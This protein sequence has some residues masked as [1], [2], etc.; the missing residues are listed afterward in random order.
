[1]FGFS[2]L[3]FSTSLTPTYNGS[4]ENFILYI[5]QDE[6][7]PLFIDQELD[8][9]FYITQDSNFNLFINQEEELLL[10]LQKLESA[11]L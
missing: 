2:H 3:P 7:F 10:K 9:L 5:K 11:A 8:F 4:T 6:I 1:M